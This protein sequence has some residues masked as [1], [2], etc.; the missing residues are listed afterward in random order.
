MQSAIRTADPT[1]LVPTHRISP[2][3]AA[4]LLMKIPEALSARQRH[5]IDHLKER[6]PGFAQLR[7]LALGFRTILLRGTPAS[8]RDWMHRARQSGMAALKRFVKN[9]ERDF[10][11][12]S[13]AVTTDWSNGPIEG[14][15][16][17]LK[18]IKR[19]MYGRAGVELLR[20]RLLP[21]PASDALHQT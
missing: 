8:L 2:K 19:H 5:I 6:C 7:Q 21:N 3:I 17:R 20:A 12:V 15:I 11:A 1:T 18:V 9:L 16:N 4:S 10:P 13:A 14:H